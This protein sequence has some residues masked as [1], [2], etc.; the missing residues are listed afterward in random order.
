MSYKKYKWEIVAKDYD[1]PL[2]RNHNFTVLLKKNSKLFGINMVVWGMASEKN[3]LYYLSDLSSWEKT[4]MA[5]RAKAMEDMMF[6][7]N[8]I[9][10][11]DDLGLKMNQW[12]EKEIFKKDLSKLTNKELLTRLKKFIDLD[13]TLFAHGR[14]LPILDFGDFSF[15]EGNLNK[16]L[17]EKVSSE[18]LNEYYKVFT[19]PFANSFS[20]DQEEKLL[21]LASDFYT[22]KWVNDVMT[23]DIVEIER[24]YP[25]FYAGLKKHADT[26][27]W[28]YYVFAGPA[29]AT[30]EFLEFVRVQLKKNISPRDILKEMREGKRKM[31]KLK[32]KY[33]KILEPN[34][35]EK[36]ILDLVGKVLWAKPRRKDIQSKTYY[37]VEKLMTEIGKRISLSTFQARYLP[38]DVIEN[39]LLKNTPVSASLAKDYYECHVCLPNDDGT[40]LVLKSDDARK[41]IKDELKV[42]NRENSNVTI[43]TFKGTA[44]R[45]GKVTGRVRIINIPSDMEKMEDGDILVSIATT[46]AI[47]PAMKKALGI[48]TD[49][50]GLTCH[51]SIVSR[52]LGITCIV[53]T[54]IATKVLKDGDLVEVDAD[55][56]IVKILERA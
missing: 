20:Q 19:E 10:K 44:A 28:V 13:S 35:F 7:Q 15:V 1:S 46:P 52:E 22:E 50:G 37:H 33:I 3:L 34:E 24:L 23:K 16:I 9:D 26:W 51:A 27:G 25:D 54:K 39:S 30:K 47:V 43:Q 56:G 21:L 18:E 55:N 8:L 17:K 5:F 38:L 6:V 42:E 41:F 53:G 11:I 48:V 31:K 29:F 2:I 40:V 12:S 4:H 14:I 36:M 32:E 49:E 45:L